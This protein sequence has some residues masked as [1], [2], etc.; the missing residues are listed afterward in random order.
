M[1]DIIV[2]LAMFST[3]IDKILCFMGPNLG[4]GPKFC[5]F[6]SWKAPLSTNGEADSCETKNLM[7]EEN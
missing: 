3:T 1:S 5:H 6:L 2:Y 7:K 4:P